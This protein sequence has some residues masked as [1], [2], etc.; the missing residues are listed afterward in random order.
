ML[1]NNPFY[2]TPDGALPPMEVRFTGLTV[3]PWPDGKRILVLATTTPF[4]K[5][6]D[7]QASIWDSAGNEV[8]TVHIVEF[9]EDRL[10]FTIHLRSQN[11][12]DGH[13]ILTAILSYPEFGKVDE[14]KR[15]F[16]T[17]EASTE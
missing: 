16:E 4:Q 13:Y 9:F 10:A 5:P 3:E 8:S 15:E 14:T 6:P 17:H 1:G 2:Q 12:V 11:K 7:L